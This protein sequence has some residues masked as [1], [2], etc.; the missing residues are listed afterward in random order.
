MLGEKTEGGKYLTVLG[1][2]GDLRITVPEGT[3][4]ALYREYE[5]SKGNKGSKWELAYSFIGGQITELEIV[6]GEFGTNLVFTFTDNGENLKLSLSASTP[7]GEDVMKKL[8]NIKLDEW[9]VFTPYSFVDEKGKPR[10]GMS[11]T[12]GD[13]KI[14]N[15][16][17]DAEAKKNI[18]G[19]PE[20]EG[21][22]SK[23]NSDKWKMY[24]T[25]CRVFMIEDITTKVLPKFV[26]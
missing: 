4:G 9:V 14:Q 13:T 26:K 17:Y 22:T 23:F 10:K 24:F 25:T 21:D 18:N 8:Q 20:T 12:Q 2:T 11:I 19:Y 16:Y 1:S 7:F 3:E 5:D 6:D 15:Y